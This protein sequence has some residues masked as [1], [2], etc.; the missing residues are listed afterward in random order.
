[1]SYIL[2]A[3]RKVERERSQPVAPSINFDHPVEQPAKYH[4]G[5]FVVIAL[6]LINLIWLAYNAL[7]P[8][9]NKTDEA[10]NTINKSSTTSNKLKTPPAETVETKIPA[11]AKTIQ[12]VEVNKQQPKQN[13]VKTNEA[14]KPQAKKEQVKNSPQSIAE[15][16]ASVGNDKPVQSKPL[17]TKPVPKPT[18]TR[19]IQTKPIQPEP[20]ISAIQRQSAAK[21][22]QIKPEPAKQKTTP[23]VTKR[24]QTRVTKTTNKP[25]TKPIAPPVKAAQPE[26][27]KAVT[28]PPKKATPVPRQQTTAERNATINIPLLRQMPSAFSEQIPE[29]K[30]NVYVYAEEADNSFVIINMRKYRIGDRIGNNLKLDDIGK[31]AIT[32]NKKGKK[33]RIAR[34]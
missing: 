12:P 1:M 25:Q 23:K 2:D 29:L 4:W 28:K 22:K 30:I 6:V 20:E 7:T 31:D 34:P 27:V 21:M 3:L 16:M 14:K 13:Q 5:R 33:F 11:K 19:P 24:D 8:K 17:Q 32:L 26:P 10:A 18:Q 9:V 15:L